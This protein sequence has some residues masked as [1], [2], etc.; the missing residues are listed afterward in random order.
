VGA[1][2]H[3]V[4]GQLAPVPVAAEDVLDALPAAW[5]SVRSGSGSRAGF[6]GT[7]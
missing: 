5:A 2:L 1:Y 4:A 3:G 7:A 6:G